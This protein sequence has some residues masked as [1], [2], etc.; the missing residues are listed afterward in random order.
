MFTLII[1]GDEAA[2]F[3]AC[4]LYDVEALS[5]V[6]HKRFDE[7]VVTAPVTT[8]PAVLNHWFCRTGFLD[9]TL[10]WWGR[11]PK[12]YYDVHGDRPPQGWDS[13]QD[14]HDALDDYFT[15]REG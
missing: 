10:L 9:G 5:V 14:L 6:K 3:A 12:A 4:R 15:K 11:D 8:D 1:K 2:A 7:C 13:E